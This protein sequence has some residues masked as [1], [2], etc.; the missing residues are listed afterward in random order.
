M[1]KLGCFLTISFFNRTCAFLCLYPPCAS[2][3]WCHLFI[4]FS[5]LSHLIISHWP[6]VSFFIPFLCPCSS[7][8]LQ[9]EYLMSALP[10]VTMHYFSA[11]LGAHWLF[12]SYN[13]PR[14][15]HYFRRWCH[16]SLIVSPMSEVKI[17]FKIFILY[18]WKLSLRP[19]I[20][21]GP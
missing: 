5:G 2:R 7:L 6:L 17:H 13:P 19:V 15:W 3:S 12:S 14:D 9:F 21:C 4:Q 8:L 10:L 16:S 11:P 18:F 1:K 20:H